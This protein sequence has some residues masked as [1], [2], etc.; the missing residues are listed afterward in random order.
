MSIGQK[1]GVLLI[2]LLDRKEEFCESS[3]PQ[4]YMI[5]FFDY[6]PLCG[7]G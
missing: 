2:R 3:L 7:F 1:W 6:D 4:K 5:H